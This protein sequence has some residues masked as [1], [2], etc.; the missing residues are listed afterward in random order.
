MLRK[1]AYII[2]SNSLNPGNLINKFKKTE[3]TKRFI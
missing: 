1:I 2:E 3:M